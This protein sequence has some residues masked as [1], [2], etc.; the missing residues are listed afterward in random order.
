MTK[1]ELID[2]IKENIE[3]STEFGFPYESNSQT[4]GLKFRDEDE[5]FTEI[6]INID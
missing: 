5:C 3:L 4:V 1:Q 6:T 2:F